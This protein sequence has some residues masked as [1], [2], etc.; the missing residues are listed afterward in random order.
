MPDGE[1]AEGG[2]KGVS[3]RLIKAGQVAT[4]LTALAGLGLF[5][6]HQLQPAPPPPVLE[7]KLSSA[8]THGPITLYNYFNSH[9]PKLQLEEAAFRKEGLGTKEIRQTLTQQ[10]VVVEFT[11]TTRGTP[12]HTWYFTG[13]MYNAKTDARI[14]EVDTNIPDPLVAPSADN[15]T[16]RPSWFQYPSRPG[17][18]YVE[19]EVD[20][21]EGNKDSISS[22]DF[23]TPRS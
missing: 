12:G 10:G 7:A 11:I 21:H 2:N 14:E 17:V 13:T 22:R 15:T 20:D 23:S 5:V 19:I 18:Y 8:Q 4:A 3:S 16:S 9:P 1:R 6:W